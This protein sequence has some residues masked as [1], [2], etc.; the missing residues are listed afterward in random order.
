M[1]SGPL[2]TGQI[3]CSYCCDL[4]GNAVRWELDLDQLLGGSL[5]R[6][7]KNSKDIQEVERMVKRRKKF[8]MLARG[9]NSNCL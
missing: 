1:G 5:G 6:L 4:L 8:V 7:V 9:E 3:G 2:S